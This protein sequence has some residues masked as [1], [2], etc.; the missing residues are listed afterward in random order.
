MQVVEGTLHDLDSAL[1]VPG[2]ED[3]DHIEKRWCDRACVN[4]SKSDDARNGL[5]GPRQALQYVE[6]LLV[7]RSHLFS[8]LLT[9]L[10]QLDATTCAIH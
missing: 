4:D 9:G 1:W 6:D 5:T 3:L 8:Q 7:G 10:G 2:L